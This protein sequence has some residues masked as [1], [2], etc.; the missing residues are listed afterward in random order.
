MVPR[1]F[2]LASQVKSL[3]SFGVLLGSPYD[4][5]SFGTFGAFEEWQLDS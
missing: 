5:L 1:W 3:R 4:L 2:Y